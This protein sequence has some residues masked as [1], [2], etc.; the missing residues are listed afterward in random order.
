MASVITIAGE[1]LFAAKAQANEQLDID[2]FI[3]ANV[4]AQDP[5]APINRDE[6]LPNDHIVHQQIVQQVG[7]INENVVVYST[8]LDSVTGPFEFNWVGLYSSVNQTLVAINHIP[9]TAKTITEPGAAGNTLNRNFGIEYSGIADLTGINVAPETWQLDFT[10]RLSGMDK[11]TQQLA[12]DMNGKD[13]FIED[14]FKVVPRATA[15]SFKILPG[16]GYVSG[17]RVELENEHVF[18]VESYPQFVYVDAW[19][20]GDTDSVWKPKLNLTIAENEIDNYIDEAGKKH[21]VIKIAQVLES[22]RVMDLR[23][24]GLQASKNYVSSVAGREW[25]KGGSIISSKEVVVFGHKK[26]FAPFA[27]NADGKK[28]VM[29][30]CPQGD[31]NFYL[32]NE[33]AV[34]EMEITV[35]DGGQFSYLSDAIQYAILFKPAGKE[36]QVSILLKSGFLISEQID[37]KNVDLSFITILS[38]DQE[39]LIK[40]DALVVKVGRWFSAFRFENSKAPNINTLFDMDKKGSAIEK[41][42]LYLINSSMKVEPGKGFKNSGAR[43]VDLT[44]NS[45]LVCPFGVFTGAGTVGIRPSSGSRIFGQYADV[46]YSE[47]GLSA[48]SAAVVSA[49]N[50]KAN[51][52][53]KG[54][55]IAQGGVTMELQGS[56]L[57]D[58]GGDALTAIYQAQINARQVKINNPKGNGILARNGANIQA[59]EALITQALEYGILAEGGAEVSCESATVTGSK[60]NVFARR[61]GKVS[62]SLGIYTGG[63]IHG[64]YATEGGSIN[65]TVSK[66]QKGNLPN[67]SDLTVAKGGRINVNERIDGGLSKTPNILDKDG[68][69]ETSDIVINSGIVKMPKAS[70]EVTI[71]HGLTVT[72][73]IDEINVNQ[74]SSLG[75]A[76]QFWVSEVSDSSFKITVDNAPSVLDVD[77]S[78]SAK[79]TK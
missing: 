3:F 32:F 56:E 6:L 2:T 8:V 21:H 4:P 25:E 68:L 19:F 57:N 62:G 55:V 12:T 49:A 72:P 46:S 18:T 27:E 13:W 67:N 11:L 22:G 58:C 50:L 24:L 40:R 42:S 30:E 78:W 29:G 44:Q 26:W 5:T 7:R 53:L 52:C 1:K 63:I 60:I 77:F 43:N 65:A 54:A 47:Y 35:G 45:S 9:S 36:P 48:G 71:N 17:L 23:K 41:T 61:G 28:V 74:N 66:Y 37:F 34:Y 73:T 70:S 16:V 51:G 79:K 59:S 76:N 39:V 10:A 31:G 69:I 33:A 75:S 14:G 15:N 20:E 38:E 64:L